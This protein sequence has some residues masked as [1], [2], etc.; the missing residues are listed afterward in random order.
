MSLQIP[1]EAVEAVRAIFAEANDAATRTL[2]RSPN[3][4]E[5]A[6]DMAIISQLQEHSAPL[7]LGQDLTVLIDTHF[8][9]NRAMYDTWEV[10]DIG[11]LI[12]FRVRGRF[13]RTKVGL[14]QSKRL[15]P[16][17]EVIAAPPSHLAYQRGFARLYAEQEDY[18]ASVKARSFDFDDTCRYVALHKGDQQEDAI[19]NYEDKE[20]MPVHYLLYNPQCLPWKVEVPLSGTPV[21]SNRIGASVV[22]SNDLRKAIESL[23]K[24]QSPSYAAVRDAASFNEGGMAGRR[25]QDFV[26]DRLIGCH[27]GFR[28][29]NQ[30]DRPLE[31][32]FFNRSGPISAA[33]AVTIDMPGD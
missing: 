10:A 29:E 8:L 19:R 15:Y 33:V 2:S 26:A 30:K 13:I 7:R 31:Q 25:L 9:G 18:E 16:K 24:G 14:L 12:I 17:K 1:P 5:P 22:S 11:I 27:E 32:L 20:G 6:L 23:E 28:T 3:V 4:H 21:F